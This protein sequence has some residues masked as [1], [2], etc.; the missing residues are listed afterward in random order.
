MD[1]IPNVALK[2]AIKAAPEIFLDIYN[3]CLAEEIFP[4]RWMRQ[5]LV[6]L[7]KNKKPPDDPSSYRPLCMLDTPGK[8][9]ERFIYN[10][11]EAAA[12]HLLADNQY[13][14][15]KGRS[16]LDAIN[17]VTGKVK[18]AISLESGGIVGARN[19]A[20]LQLLMLKMPLI[21]PGRKISAGH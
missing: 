7:L 12:G 19:T 15:R 14:F 21:Q 13:S 11:I 3:T 1:N 6:L 4:E 5:T 16:T 8:M 17:Q 20:C 9:L 10:R 18:E 2:T